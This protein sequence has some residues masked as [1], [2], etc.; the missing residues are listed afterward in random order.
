MSENVKFSLRLIHFRV[1]ID[2]PY[3]QV[4]EHL[5]QLD[6]WLH[7]PSFSELLSTNDTPVNDTYKCLSKISLLNVP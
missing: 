2:V 1:F 5:D 4:T 7:L 6:H 3:P